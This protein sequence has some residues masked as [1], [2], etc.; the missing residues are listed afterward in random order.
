[1]YSA[2]CVNAPDGTTRLAV[3]SMGL[4]TKRTP[5]FSKNSDGAYGKPALHRAKR[6]HAL[7]A[8]KNEIDIGYT[9][10]PLQREVHKLLDANRFCVLV[11]HRRF[12]KT[13][14]AINHLLKRAIEEKKPNPRLAYVA[15]TYRQAKNVAW[16]YLKQFSE[17]I[18]GTKYHETELRCDLANGARISLLGSENPSS[19]RGIYLDMA[20]I[21]E[22]ADCPEFV[23]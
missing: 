19:L 15:P 13:V 5:S 11:M 6:D 22:T 7:M 20:V 4:Q 12:G 3:F 9:P 10:R 18:P 16:D 21:D 17:R 23:S 8:K 1:M 14:C 2:Y